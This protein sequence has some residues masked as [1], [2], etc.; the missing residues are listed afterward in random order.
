MFLS[1]TEGEY[2]RQNLKFVTDFY[3]LVVIQSRFFLIGQSVLGWK[4]TRRDLSLM[5]KHERNLSCQNLPID[6]WSFDFFKCRQLFDYHISHIQGGLLSK[7]CL[8]VSM[9]SVLVHLCCVMNMGSVLVHL[10]C[11]MNIIH[12]TTCLSLPVGC[13]QP[14]SNPIQHFVVTETRER[15][16]T[17]YKA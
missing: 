11:V 9:G 5:S 12:S 13:P 17:W 1:V 3:C 16:V 14:A 4:L 7:Y 10:C 2:K 6:C 15:D 8:A